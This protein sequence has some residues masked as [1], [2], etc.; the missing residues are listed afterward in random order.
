MERTPPLNASSHALKLFDSGCGTGNYSCV[1]L[2]DYGFLDIHLSDF[3]S[4]MVGEA[5]KN[6]KNALTKSASGSAKL[7]FST[8]NMCNMPN[9]PS[10][11]FDAVCN[12]QTVHHLRPDKNFQ[13]LKNACKEWARILK[14]GGRLCVNWSPA[15][16]Q[17]E[18]MWWAELIPDAQKQWE[19]RAPSVDVMKQALL[20]AGFEEGR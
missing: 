11:Y 17:R 1:F 9:I 2:T 12:N 5:E 15:E 14:T 4:A 16:H 7:T 20:E 18:G 3:N 13:D 19:P 6:M 10:N 8:D